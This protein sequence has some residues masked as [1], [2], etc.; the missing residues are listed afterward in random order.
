MT[1]PPAGDGT[2][3]AGGPPGG[4]DPAASATDQPAGAPVGAP[5]T[6][7]YRHPKRET[8]IRCSRC[9][10][11]ICPDCM[12]DAPVGFQCPECVRQGHVPT[13]TQ[14]GATRSSRP[15]L[16]T[17]LLI[18]ANV[19][20][21]LV[22]LRQGDRFDFRFLEVGPTPCLSGCGTGIS[23]GGYY[24]LVT[25]MFLHVGLLHIALNMYALYWLGRMVEPVLGW[26]RFAGLYFAAGIAGNALAYILAPNSPA[27]GASGAIY[28]LFAAMWIVARRMGADT[29]QITGIIALNLVLSFVIARISWQAHIGGLVAGGLVALVLAFAPRMRWRPVLHAAVIVAV[30]G[31]ALLAVVAKAAT[32]T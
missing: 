16:V 19:L 1:L 11:P 32:L 25:A 6:T 4:V 28:G 20:V 15:E 23:E 27:E 13:R 12:R 3:S 9:D 14:V 5:P 21:F 26:W 31:V 10:R 17:R 30:A 24:R 18:A 2:G 7:C 22:Q 29:S 8:Y